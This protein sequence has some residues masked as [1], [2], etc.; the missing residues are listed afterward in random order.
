MNS[1][2]LISCPDCGDPKQSSG[3]QYCANCGTKIDNIPSERL[4]SGGEKTFGIVSFAGYY[5][6][7]C[8]T[9]RRIIQFQEIGDRWKYLLNVAMKPS[10]LIIDTQVDL[11]IVLDF[12]KSQILR[13]E[14]SSILLENHGRFKRGHFSVF[15]KSGEAVDLARIDVNV[16][17]KSFTELG[18]FVK[19]LYPEVTKK[20][21]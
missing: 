16:D 6:S 8:F 11:K 17:Q 20:V 18:V 7:I 19:S 9:D 1:M 13:G 14:I 15:K 3:A 21:S 12:E 4:N 2:S 10:H 5:R